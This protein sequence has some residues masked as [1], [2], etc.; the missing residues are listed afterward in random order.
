MPHVRRFAGL[1]IALLA[2][3]V[4][5]CEKEVREAKQPAG[6]TPQTVAASAATQPTGEATTAT[7]KL[8]ERP[9]A[10]QTQP[11]VTFIN[12]DGLG[13]EFPPTKLMLY[14]SDAETRAELFSDLPKSALRKYDGNELYLDMKLEIIVGS[15]RKLDGAT[16]RFKSTKSGKVN[17]PNGIFLHGQTTHLQPFDV[18][19]TFERRGEQLFAQIAGR[20]RAYEDTTPDALAP[21]VDV[22]GELPVEIAGKG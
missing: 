6:S 5:A 13:A 8:R 18:L 1:T 20:F 12:I 10:T 19:V 21:F 17:S 9:P 11:A 15:G 14:P 7:A 3:A 2:L 4:G 16:W 22:N